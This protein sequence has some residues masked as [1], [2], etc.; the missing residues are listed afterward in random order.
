MQT[1][2]ITRDKSEMQDIFVSDRLKLIHGEC[3]EVMRDMPTEEFDAVITDP[4]YMIGACSAGDKNTKSGSWADIE[5]SAYWYSKWFSEAR[6]VLKNTGWLL[7]F[8][9]WRSI[10]VYLKA[11]YEIKA[12]ANS[13]LIWDKMWI[14]TASK[15]QLRTRYEIVLFSGREDAVISNRSFNDIYGCK[16]HSGNCGKYHPAEKPIALMEKL[17]TETVPIS[18][19]VLDPF[20]G[21][22]TTLLACCNL[23]VTCTGIERDSTYYKIACERVRQRL[24]QQDEPCRR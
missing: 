5:N 7:V 23:N 14:G 6:R 2:T 15:N 13:C 4:P 24:E 17:I 19:N 20:C 11:L 1:V 22:G 10:P 3:I 12:K 8:G 21:S 9:N 18:G 16:W